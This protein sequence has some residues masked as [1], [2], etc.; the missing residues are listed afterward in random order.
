[1]H[2][3]QENREGIWV[4]E[5]ADGLHAGEWEMIKKYTFTTFDYKVV[6][7]LDS[8]KLSVTDATDIATFW[9]GYEDVLNKCKDEC[10]YE[11]VA[12]WAAGS[13]LAFAMDGYKLGA[14]P[15]EIQKRE[16]WYDHDFGL[17]FIEIEF[18]EIPMPDEWN[19]EDGSNGR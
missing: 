10:P 3:G 19:L 18:A 17:K 7:E 9:S 16:G 2:G 11:A 13:A 6:M 4:H 14:I 5:P 15:A 12:R 8:E 1:M